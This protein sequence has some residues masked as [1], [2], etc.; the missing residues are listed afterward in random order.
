MEMLSEAVS[1]TPLW[2]TQVPI[3]VGMTL[4]VFASLVFTLKRIFNDK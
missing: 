3:T 1:E 4:F 2:L